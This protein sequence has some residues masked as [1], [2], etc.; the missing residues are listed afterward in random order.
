MPTLPRLA[1]PLS[2]HDKGALLKLIDNVRRRGVAE[3]RDQVSVGVWG[4]GAPVFDANRTLV[5][6]VMIAA[7]TDRAKHNHQHLLASIRS[8][9]EEMSRLLGLVGEYVIVR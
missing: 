3:S 6:A 2:R 7:L 9:G 5:A 8:A 4:F 1:S